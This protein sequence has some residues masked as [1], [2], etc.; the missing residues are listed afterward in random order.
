MSVLSFLLLGRDVWKEIWLY[1]SERER[2]RIRRVCKQL[3][4]WFIGFE[5][6]GSLNFSRIYDNFKNKKFAKRTIDLNYNYESINNQFS[7]GLVFF[8]NAQACEFKINFNGFRIYSKDSLKLL[9]EHEGKFF[10]FEADKEHIILSDENFIYWHLSFCLLPSGILQLENK[11]MLCK[12]LH[13]VSTKFKYP[14]FLINETLKHQ[15]IDVRTGKDTFKEHNIPHYSDLS[16]IQLFEEYFIIVRDKRK[17]IQRDVLKLKMDHRDEFGYFTEESFRA[18]EKRWKKHESF[19]REY[20]GLKDKNMKLYVYS[21][22]DMKRIMKF[23]CPSITGLH[24]DKDYLFLLFQGYRDLYIMNTKSSTV[25]RKLLPLGFEDNYK[26]TTINTQFLVIRKN[27]ESLSFYDWSDHFTKVKQ[28]G[29][30]MKEIGDSLHVVDAFHPQ[31]G[32]SSFRTQDNESI[33]V[34]DDKT[35]KGFEIKFKE[36]VYGII[37]DRCSK[38]YCYLLD[39]KIL[40]FDFS[41]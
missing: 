22:K 12:L 25:I 39:G 24:N 15:L 38:I 36:R 23:E 1:L 31:L 33:Y 2:H 34:F 14:F 3:K 26:I 16:Y 7:L 10:S 21:F 9:Y 41:F 17:P 29:V 19:I 4:E 28:I 27:Q 35:K 13:I 30:T 6:I 37:G 18:D 11:T 20:H 32:L 5:N 40:V 8:G